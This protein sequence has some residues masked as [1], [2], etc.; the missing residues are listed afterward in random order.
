MAAESNG[1]PSGAP[2]TQNGPQSIPPTTKPAI[3]A[4][5]PEELTPAQRKAKAKAEKAARRAQVKE[6]KAAAATTP[7]THQAGSTVAEVKGA[8]GKGKQDGQPGPG[9][10]GHRP[11]M[12]GRRPSMPV[13]EK[14]VRGGIP[15]SFS[16]VPIA[17]RIPTSHAYKDVHP[18]VLAVG[19]QMA[20]FALK[21]S[22][23]RLEATMLAF[24]KVCIALRQP[25]IA[26]TRLTQV[27]GDRVVRDA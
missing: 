3:A 20:S 8:K 10:G 25:G 17:K 24:R 1:A 4:P 26:C 27:T 11:S 18:A 21:D 12:S 7:P 13:L 16:H 14:D 6:A 9:R 19:Q 22:I 15:E 2:A 5:N 23:S